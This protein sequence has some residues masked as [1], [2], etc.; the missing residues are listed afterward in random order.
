MTIDIN[1]DWR[2]TNQLEFL[3]RAHLIQS[4]YIQPHENWDHDHCKFC[5]EKIDAST[6]LAICTTD[7]R[8]WI[9]LECF[10]DFKEAFEWVLEDKPEN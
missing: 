7:Y 9:C 3:K 8:K 10:A 6:E 4:K 1:N 5:S 2:I